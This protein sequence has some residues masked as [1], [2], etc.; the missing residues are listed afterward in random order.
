MNIKKWIHLIIFVISV[1]SIIL[2]SILVTILIYNHINY[3]PHN[4][5]VDIDNYVTEAFTST[6]EYNSDME[7]HISK[8]VYNASNMYKYYKGFNQNQPIK[9]SVTLNEIN[10]HKIN[11]KI[12]VYMQY[13]FEVH[14]STGNL[15]SG[16]WK[17]P[18]VFT[19]TENDD[20]IYL[21]KME[22]FETP[23]EVPK[24]YR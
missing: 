17:G 15:V 4:H 10:Q 14:D 23:N 16:S 5:Y 12:Y 13:D 1:I 6:Q 20:G 24:M 11:D 2:V 3:N 8:D 18:V 7:K 21:E 9:L 22:E 19:V